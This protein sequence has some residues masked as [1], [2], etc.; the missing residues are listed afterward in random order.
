M[1]AFSLAWDYWLW[2]VSTG[3][4]H[5][6]N[7]LLHCGNGLIAYAL[8]RR[9]SFSPLSSLAGALGWCA[10]PLSATS[11]AWSN[12]RT[13]E[14]MAFFY[15]GSLLFLAAPDYRVRH[16]VLSLVLGS[17]SLGSKEMASTLPVTGLLIVRLARLDQKRWRLFTTG[18]LLAVVLLYV[19][20]W[21]VLLP[22]NANYAIAQVA[23]WVRP[24]GVRGHPLASLYPVVFL[25]TT[26]DWYAGAEVDGM[27]GWYL[28]SG[29][30]VWPLA[31]ALVRR[32]AGRGFALKMVTLGGIWPLVTALPLLGLKGGIDLYR[33]GML[34]AMGFG[35]SWAAL[36]SVT[37]RKGAGPARWMML[38]LAIWFGHASLR[39]A[40][41]WG[42]GGFMMELGTRWKLE[43]SAWQ[44]QI[45]PEMKQLFLEQ[46]DRAEH[47]A[48]WVN[49][50]R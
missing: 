32:L 29:V 27:P 31:W 24:A 23:E 50:R 20:L 16:S 26:Y 21:V 11:A 40:E 1:V 6:T 30:L 2:G 17:L 48:S 44:N 9:L 8:L 47:A 22:G 15:L 10:H 41:A 12:E 4:Y 18:G 36:V 25:P 33:L 7:L 45:R 38:F 37:E 43:S 46:V 19:V 34:S 35:I 3:G 13:D 28:L 42:P 49:A 5:L 14:I 39:T